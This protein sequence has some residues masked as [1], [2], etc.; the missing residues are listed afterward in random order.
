MK[1]MNCYTGE[2][3]VTLYLK[4]LEREID[5]VYI[6]NQECQDYTV[7]EAGASHTVILLDNSLSIQEE[8]RSDIKTFLS[9]L[10]ALGDENDTFTIATFSEDVTYLVRDSSDYMELKE[11]IDSITFENQESFLTRTLY[12][13]LEE[14]QQNRTDQYTRMIVLADGAEDEALGYTYEELSE[15]IRETNIPVY[16]VGFSNANNEENLKTMFS[17]SRISNAKS[18]LPEETG[19]TE[20]LKDISEDSDLI[21]VDVRPETGLCDGAKKTV[22]IGSGEDFC[23]IEAEMPFQAVSAE[24]NQPTEETMV[25]PFETDTQTEETVISETG[26]PVEAASGF[27][28]SILPVLF[29]AILF[30][31][32]TAAILVVKR[33]RRV[34]EQEHGSVDLSEIGHSSETAV[35][36]SPPGDKTE[37]LNSGHYSDSS[38]TDIL[39]VGKT[40]KLCLQDIHE[41]SKTFEYPLR[42]S[43]LIGKDQSR[44]QI[45]INYNRYISSVHCEV[46]PK[47]GGYVV[48]DGGDTVIAS[49]NGTFVNGVKAAPELPLPAGSILKLGEVSFKVT[50]R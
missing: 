20:I 15:I 41:P 19:F 17:L 38:K 35:K 14:L 2:N 43:I 7:E 46:L 33:K 42:E 48:R 36:S 26:S 37:I 30:A 32:I 25:V 4:D 27:R 44:C 1:I 16:T 39:N 5:H 29:F 11:K 8:Y 22:R 6:G 45:V 34:K 10:A 21:R 47:A 49:T 40:T 24:L 13:V 12:S 28:I 23:T 31:A 9:D 50:Y 3:T 18:Y